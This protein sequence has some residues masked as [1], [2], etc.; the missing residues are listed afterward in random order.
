[1]YYPPFKVNANSPSQTYSSLSNELI[2]AVDSEAF[3]AYLGTNSAE[4][5]T[6]AL[7]GCSS[8]SVSTTEI[9]ANDDHIDDDD[10]SDDGLSDRDLALIVVCTV[11]GGVLLI[12]VV[13]F[14]Y[15]KRS[16]ATDT[17][18]RNEPKNSMVNPL[19]H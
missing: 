7:S 10:S 2:K 17:S 12:L 19:Q 1:M 9:S 6:P 18:M 4:N 5:G 3:N 11:I 15:Q 13:Y 8:T 14:V 16:L